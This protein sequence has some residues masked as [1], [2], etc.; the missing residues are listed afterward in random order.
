MAVDYP[1]INGRRYSWASV[2]VNVGARQFLGVK[3]INYTDKLDPTT[4]HG[5]GQNIIGTTA[6]M[7]SADG[8]VEFYQEEGEEL[9][10][11]IG[12]GWGNRALRIQIQFI[13]D[14]QPTST[15]KLTVRLIGAGN[16]GS[17]GSDALTY[18]FTMHFLD[19]IDRNGVRLVPA[20]QPAA[21]GGPVV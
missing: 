21:L 15:H 12:N 10:H 4:I 17:E 2:K 5:T 8:D 13:D 14:L 7:Y 18:K 16:G 3:S 9:I 1:S 11:A 19:A 6:G 20:I